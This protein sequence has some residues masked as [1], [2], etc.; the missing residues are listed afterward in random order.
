M[1]VFQ[2]KSEP[3]LYNKL[4]VAFSALRTFKF[5]TGQEQETVIS[6]GIDSPTMCP[7]DQQVEDKEPRRAKSDI[8]L[9]FPNQPAKLIK[10]MVT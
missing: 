6:E 5:W 3:H 2:T 9:L 4:H 8:I 10:A 7:C 1:S